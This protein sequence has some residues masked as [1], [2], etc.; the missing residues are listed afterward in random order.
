MRHFC[1]NSFVVAVLTRYYFRYYKSDLVH[2]IHFSCFFYFCALSLKMICLLLR[3][4]VLR[5][6]YYTKQTFSLTLFFLSFS[7]FSV[8]VHLLRWK[9]VI[10]H[11]QY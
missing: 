10:K 3:I 2:V 5:S 4:T 8:D 9:L 7:L 6:T 11:V 1:E